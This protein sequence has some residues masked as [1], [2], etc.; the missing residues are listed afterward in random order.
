MLELE[1]RL[2]LIILCEFSTVLTR[3]LIWFSTWWQPLKIYNGKELDECE[4]KILLVRVELWN[5]P[6]I[7]KGWKLDG[8]LLI[9]SNF[10]NFGCF[11]FIFEIFLVFFS[12]FFWFTKELPSLENVHKNR[13]IPSKILVDLFSLLMLRNLQV[14]IIYPWTCYSNNFPKKRK[15]NYVWK[16]NYDVT[17]TKNPLRFVCYFRL[18]N[19]LHEFCVKSLW[20]QLFLNARNCYI[21]DLIGENC[22][23]WDEFFD[24]L[25]FYNFELFMQFRMAIVSKIWS[26][27]L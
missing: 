11:L 5:F 1:N 12:S 15:K 8:F 24:V 17:K 20:L 23:V 25:F 14:Y 22:D 16:R 9:W 18:R 6:G 19:F 10:V 21:F 27:N 7:F 26:I 3:I 2:A 13:G 4:W